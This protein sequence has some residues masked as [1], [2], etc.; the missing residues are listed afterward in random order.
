MRHYGCLPGN[1]INGTTSEAPG[2]GSLRT[3]I[4]ARAALVCGLAGLAWCVWSTLD[5]SAAQADRPPSVEQ[6]GGL[7]D[8]AGHLPERATDRAREAVA[9]VMPEL[10]REAEPEQPILST[11]PERAAPEPSIELEPP[12]APP[13]DPTS[14]PAP[15]ANPIGEIVEEV[16]DALP[17][18]VSPTS[19]PPAHT[20]SEP[21]HIVTLPG[22]VNPTILPVAPVLL[23]L[24]AV[25]GPVPAGE[26]PANPASASATAARDVPPC[27][28]SRSARNVDR[29]RGVARA[30]L[31]RQPDPGRAEHP[32]PARPSP[33]V[34]P[35]LGEAAPPVV[36]PADQDV[37]SLL[38]GTLPGAARAPT[39]ARLG[40]LRP[41]SHMFTAWATH[42]DPRPA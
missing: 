24:P 5:V 41:S 29:S 34:S 2:G 13:P 4:A 26:S 38:D 23:P 39:L 32:R 28:G 27:D 17:P 1:P 3:K 7:L 19:P 15:P 31:D 8:R 18:A 33:P 16:V 30:A 20:G 42:L 9:E 11:D 40:V 21:G 12:T 35:P 14:A 37:L 36:K 10:A 22:I 25:I 6:P